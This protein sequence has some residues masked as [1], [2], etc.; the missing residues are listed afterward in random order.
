MR[1]YLAEDDPAIEVIVNLYLAVVWAEFGGLIPEMGEEAIRRVREKVP[2]DT[3]Y[4][5]LAKLCPNGEPI[6]GKC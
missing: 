3:D 4:A 5:N 1:L 6:G 2:S